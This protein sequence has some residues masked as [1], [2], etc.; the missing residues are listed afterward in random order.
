MLEWFGVVSGLLYLFLEIRQKSS[1]WIV[2]FISSFVYVF[3][4]FQSKFYA[5]ALLNLYYVVI[6]V[7]GFW[8]W[9]VNKSSIEK[10]ISEQT[11]T[12]ITS[13]MMVLL[14]MFTIVVFLFIY[15]V[16]IK[17]TDSPVPIGDSVVTTLSLVATWMLT[18][19]MIEQ[20]FIWM[21]VNGLS[22]YLFMYKDLK[23]TAFLYLCYGVL[24]VVGYLKWKRFKHID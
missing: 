18:R 9:K 21:F 4:F 5:D 20:W 16:L 6:S 15:F 13:K 10:E 3:V 14:S 24:S 11:Y 8:I 1:M 22:V 17:Y 19:K 12:T 2:G 7:Y 23:P